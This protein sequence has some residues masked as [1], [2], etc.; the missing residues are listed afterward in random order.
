MGH[1]IGALTAVLSRRLLTRSAMQKVVHGKNLTSSI[2]LGVLWD[3][4]PGRDCEPGTFAEL[5]RYGTVH[6][7]QTRKTIEYVQ[8]PAP[9]TT[10]KKG[11]LEP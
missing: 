5:L 2:N 9:P 7:E 3:E 1:P 4:N 11:L 6:F 10:L 8:A